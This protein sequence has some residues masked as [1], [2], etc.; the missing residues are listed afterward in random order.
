MTQETQRPLALVRAA[1]PYQ[2]HGPKQ[3]RRRPSSS[4]AVPQT[5][6]KGLVN[7]HMTVTT[8]YSTG[9]VRQD[10]AQLPC[11]AIGTIVFPAAVMSH[12]CLM[13]AMT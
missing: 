11:N 4:S 8:M 3:P 12:A 5:L 13:P 9:C 10:K 1:R 2:P 7:S 6:P